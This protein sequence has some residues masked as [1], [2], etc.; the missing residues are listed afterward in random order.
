MWFIPTDWQIAENVSAKASKLCIF[1]SFSIKL[2]AV[3]HT[4]VNGISYGS[5]SRGGSLGF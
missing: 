4:T 5:S 3:T 2:G 1:F